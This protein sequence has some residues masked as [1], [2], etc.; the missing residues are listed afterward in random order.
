MQLSKTKAISHTNVHTKNLPHLLECTGEGSYICSLALT[1]LFWVN[2]YH[3]TTYWL[4]VLVGRRFLYLC[5]TLILVGGALFLAK[6]IVFHS[7]F[8]QRLNAVLQ[9]L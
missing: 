3:S 7:F 6:S 2:A 8:K 9:M 5:V 1:N 4:Y